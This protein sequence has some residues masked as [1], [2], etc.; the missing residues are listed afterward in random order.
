MNVHLQK[1]KAISINK[2]P[3]HGPI[4]TL[5]KGSIRFKNTVHNFTVVT[6]TNYKAF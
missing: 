5:I 6:H 2:F 1:I 4:H 3:R